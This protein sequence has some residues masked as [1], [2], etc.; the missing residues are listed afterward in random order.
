[1]TDWTPEDAIEE[2]DGKKR[3]NGAT[4]WSTP[5]P[6]T[7]TLAYWLSRDLPP[8][9]FLFG[10]VISTTSPLLLVG[11]SGLRQD[12]S[13]YRH[14]RRYRLRQALPALV[15]PSSSPCPLCRWRNVPSPAARTPH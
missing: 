2:P 13:L 15:Y 7:L 3:Q 6:A 8:P 14:R 12:A 10:E 4:E 5:E 1:M 9:D 11:P